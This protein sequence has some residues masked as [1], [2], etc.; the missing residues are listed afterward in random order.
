MT[1][2]EPDLYD[3]SE[4]RF[5]IDVHLLAQE[6]SEEKGYECRILGKDDLWFNEYSLRS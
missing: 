3:R 4:T 2:T 6:A 1:T 5:C